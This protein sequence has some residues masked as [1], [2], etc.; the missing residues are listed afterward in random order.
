MM[1]TLHIDYHTQWG[2]SLHVCG[3]SEI[4]G[5]DRENFSA[6]MNPAGDRWTLHLDID[7][8]E[9]PLRYRYIVVRDGKTIRREYGS[10]HII[11]APAGTPMLTVVDSWKDMPADKPFYSSAFTK[12]VCKRADA[13]SAG[14]LPEAGKIL[15]ELEA[16]MVAPEQAIAICGSTPT[17]GAWNP[18]KA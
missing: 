1:L 11:E 7:E 6:P 13:V 12:G 4:L 9:L 5:A 16:P 10:E 17:L 15:F 3:S 2:E 8:Q 18:D 14:V